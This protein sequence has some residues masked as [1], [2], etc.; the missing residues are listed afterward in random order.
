M[1]KA[2]R[3]STVF[4]G[5]PT[6]DR[7][8]NR[9]SVITQ[10]PPFTSTHQNH[11]PQSPSANQHSRLD[12]T[13]HPPVRSNRN[14]HTTI[15]IS[16]PGGNMP[17]PKMRATH[18]N[19][20]SEMQV[21][22][23]PSQT[24]VLVCDFLDPSHSSRRSPIPQPTRPAPV[25]EPFMYDQVSLLQ[26]K[27]RH[28]LFAVDTVAIT[29][30]KKGLNRFVLCHYYG[31]R[32]DTRS[33]CLDVITSDE[34]MQVVDTDDHQQQ[35]QLATAGIDRH[36]MRSD[37]VNGLTH[38]VDAAHRRAMR[39]L[40]QR[41]A[42]NLEY[43][44]IRH[45]V[46]V[47]V[48]TERGMGLGKWRR[49][50][51][52]SGNTD[53]TDNELKERET[54]RRRPRPF[55]VGFIDNGSDDALDVVGEAI[56]R[57]GG[58]AGVPVMPCLITTI[59]RIVTETI[60][61][62]EI[63]EQRFTKPMSRVMLRAL[64]DH[65]FVASDM[66]KVWS[67]RVQL[68]IRDVSLLQMSFVFDFFVNN[69]DDIVKAAQRGLNA[70]HDSDLELMRYDELRLIRD[71][72][73]AFVA[74]IRTVGAA[75][76]V[77]GR[78][79]CER[80]SASLPIL[81]RLQERL[82]K[83]VERVIHPMQYVVGHAV[84]AVGREWRT[85]EKERMYGC[86]TLLDPRFKA[87]YFS[88]KEAVDKV[89]RMV[90]ELCEIERRRSDLG[91]GIGNSGMGKYGGGVGSAHLRKEVSSDGH[92]LEHF[93]ESMMAEEGTSVG[94]SVMARLSADVRSY[95]GEGATELS[96]DV[97]EY[98]ERNQA[99]WPILTK[100]ATQ[101]SLIPCCC[102]GLECAT[103]GAGEGGRVTGG[104][105][106]CGDV[107]DVKIDARVH[108]HAQ[109]DAGMDTKNRQ[110]GSGA[111]VARQQHVTTGNGMRGGLSGV[112]PLLSLVGGVA[113]LGLD[114]PA[115]EFLRSNVIMADRHL[116]L[117]GDTRSVS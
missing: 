51:E 70:Q 29:V 38:D 32:L 87:D 113:K 9:P 45:K 63:F 80:C 103:R 23:S 57:G 27:I 91:S 47:V 35:H 115:I 37:I 30:E 13:K 4:D 65:D 105:G 94:A 40:L 26:S 17:Q 33:V 98:W 54:G 107:G 7:N 5:D 76:N 86:A 15:G 24:D 69:M 2:G 89:E 12:S 82:N 50:P 64:M 62:H 117:T 114:D 44:E 110:G 61:R 104:E 20:L 21:P 74:A 59:E 99:R 46:N 48:V 102:C 84:H 73:D 1:A 75:R 111:D 79:R 101:F 8:F 6:V 49:L 43:W 60:C 41:V 22:L 14:S 11:V 77:Y 71:V 109:E 10:L 116:L 25:H 34:L 16:P 88:C 39:K 85:L 112:S 31:P 96:Q 81:C 42:N 93:M 67:K 90:L 97:E 56:M 72:L 92:A 95:L 66:A 68:P 108:V 100:V 3:P 78:W 53:G 106:G 58:D 19:F 18:A 55:S 28:S 83:V 36:P 52:A